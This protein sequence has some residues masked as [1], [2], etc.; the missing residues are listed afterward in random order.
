MENKDKNLNCQE[1]LIQDL[2]SLEPLKFEIVKDNFKRVI[3]ETMG[4][5]FSRFEKNFP[6][7]EETIN[8]VL[9]TI[10][11]IASLTRDFDSVGL[12]NSTI[13]VAH[14]KAPADS[15]ILELMSATNLIYGDYFYSSY[16]VEGKYLSTVNIEYLQKGKVMNLP[17]WDEFWLLYSKFSGKSLPMVNIHKEPVL[18]STLN[19]A[20]SGLLVLDAVSDDEGNANLVFTNDWKN[21][22]LYQWSDKATYPLEFSYITGYTIPYLKTYAN[23]PVADID[24]DINLKDYLGRGIS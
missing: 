12:A 19:G 20:F 2:D 9:T 5:N 13:T 24:M 22:V 15:S 7:Y 4:I 17:E 18:L 6:N 11:K 8:N 3:R 1:N 10:A 14:Y 21:L 16:D 23:Y